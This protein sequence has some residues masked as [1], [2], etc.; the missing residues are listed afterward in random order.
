MCGM[1]SL[2]Q[3]LLYDDN[4]RSSWG[5]WFL[6]M[7]LHVHVYTLPYV[8]PTGLAAQ[9]ASVYLTVVVTIERY[10]IDWITP[11]SQHKLKYIEI[12]Q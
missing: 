6:D 8:Y 4:V 7:M 11:I 9:T 12:I 5:K 1:P 2:S 3:H 10:A